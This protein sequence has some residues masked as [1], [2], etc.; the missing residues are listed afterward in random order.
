MTYRLLSHICSTKYSTSSSPHCWRH[1]R[2]SPYITCPSG[3]RLLKYDWT[4]LWRWWM[5]PTRTSCYLLL[6]SGAYR[7]LIEHTAFWWNMLPDTMWLEKHVTKWRKLPPGAYWRLMGCRLKWETYY[8]LHEHIAHWRSI[9]LHHL[10]FWWHILLPLKLRQTWRNIL[11]TGAM[12]YPKD[13][14]ASGTKYYSLERIVTWCN[15][16]FAWRTWQR[17]LI[18]EGENLYLMWHRLTWYSKQSFSK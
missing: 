3:R 16:R 9:L 12:S 17:L 6:P 2:R 11:S 14:S 10:V 4:F 13:H 18:H 15:T 7:V 8:W 5:V 1:N